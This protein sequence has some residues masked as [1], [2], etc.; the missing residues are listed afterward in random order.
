MLVKEMTD[1]LA[2]IILLVDFAVVAPIGIYHRLR[3]RTDEKLDRREEG[4]PILLSLRP[5]AL[6]YMAG[7]VAFV[8]VPSSMAWASLGLPSAARWSGIAFGIAAAG[9]V[10][11]TFR[12]LG[13]NLTDT[14]VTRRDANLVKSGPYRWVR[15]PFYVSFALAAIANTLVTAN[16]FLA[17]TGA[18]VF[19]LLVARTSIEEKKLVERFGAEYLDYMR[20]TGR[21]LP[22]FRRA[23]S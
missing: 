20:R 11:W 2:R 4:W 1:D 23:I 13:H 6:A 19:L 12:S 15:H 18:G 5:L 3:S 8:A 22:R 10:S 21:F 9:L 7:L 16:A 14:V 17:I